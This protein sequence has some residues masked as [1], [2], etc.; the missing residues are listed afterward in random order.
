MQIAQFR[1]GIVLF[2]VLKRSLQNLLHVVAPKNKE[3]ASNQ[4]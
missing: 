4:I 2:F 3:V 1:K